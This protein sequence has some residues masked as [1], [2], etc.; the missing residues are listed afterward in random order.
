MIRST[1][2]TRPN[3]MYFVHHPSRDGNVYYP[4]FRKRTDRAADRAAFE[5]LTH[6]IV[7]KQHHEGT[8]DPAVVEYL[9]AGV[10]LNP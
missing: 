8:L 7:M 4:A 2:L 3:N 6:Q 9:L 10:G 5:S 1:S